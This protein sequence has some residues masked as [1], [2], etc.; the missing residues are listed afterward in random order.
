MSGVA[1]LHPTEWSFIHSAKGFLQFPATLCQCSQ[2]RMQTHPDWGETVTKDE[3][4]Y[5]AQC[6]LITTCPLALPFATGFLFWIVPCCFLECNYLIQLA[7]IT[8][9]KKSDPDINPVCVTAIS[10]PLF[11]DTH[12]HTSGNQKLINTPYSASGWGLCYLLAS[13]SS[14]LCLLDTVIFSCKFFMCSVRVSLLL[15][16]RITRRYL[17]IA[18]H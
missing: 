14:C 16:V 11:I 18:K 13:R 3:W 6:L 2:N 12:K 9:K 10:S 4:R 7:P 5:C 8:M 1:V 15:N 17:F